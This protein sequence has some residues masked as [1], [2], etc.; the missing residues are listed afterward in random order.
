MKL[1]DAECNACGADTSMPCR[2][3][4]RAELRLHLASGGA[5][6]ATQTVEDKDGNRVH[7]ARVL[8]AAARNVSAGQRLPQ[9]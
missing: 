9:R 5:A 2:E 4:T 1:T 7:L 6:M 3:L 8:R